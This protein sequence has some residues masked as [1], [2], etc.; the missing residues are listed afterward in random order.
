MSGKNYHDNNSKNYL[1]LRKR[2]KNYNEVDK[3]SEA[4]SS[5]KH[6]EEI[7]NNEYKEQRSVSPNVACISGGEHSHMG[8]QLIEGGQLGEMTNKRSYREVRQYWT[9]HHVVRFYFVTRVYNPY[10]ESILK[11]FKDDPKPDFVIMNSTLWDISRYGSNSIAEYKSNLN[12]LMQRMKEVLKPSKHFLWLITPETS[13]EIRGGFLLPGKSK[14]HSDLIF[15][16][17]QANHFCS[18]I[19][20]TY[21]FDVLDLNYFMQTQSHKRERDGIH[22][23]SQAHRRI[24][25]YIVQHLCSVCIDR[26]SD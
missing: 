11:D 2:H 15:S 6:K 8:D 17:T 9:D 5:K 25:N 14:L 20:P 4:E 16:T 18:Q 10:V 3:D 7:G 21:G 1:S 26:G 24:T 22:W 12:K 19:I 23:N 13:R